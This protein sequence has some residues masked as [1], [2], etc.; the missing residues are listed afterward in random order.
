MKYFIL[1]MWLL[2]A[3]VSCKNE[4]SQVAPSA[5]NALMPCTKSF[6]DSA[7]NFNIHFPEN[8]NFDKAHFA[9]VEDRTYGTDIFS[10]NIEMGLEGNSNKQVA[11]SFLNA[12]QA[13]FKQ[14]DSNFKNLNT[15]AIKINNLDAA[16]A[17]ITTIQNKIAYKKDMYAVAIDDKIFYMFC[18]ALD[19]TYNDHQAIFTQIINTIKPLHP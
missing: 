5:A 14:A 6:S 16:K 9:I 8:W 13:A 17:T 18:N 19:S 2:V 11:L 1:T 7:Q 10:E 3:F 12:S 15:T 4:V